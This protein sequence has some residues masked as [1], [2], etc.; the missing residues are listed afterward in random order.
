MYIWKRRLEC[1]INCNRPVVK[2]RSCL[3]KRATVT[4]LLQKVLFYVIK[5]SFFRILIVVAGFRVWL[6]EFV[7]SPNSSVELDLGDLAKFLNSLLRRGLLGSTFCK[8]SLF[9]GRHCSFRI[10]NR[11]CQS[12]LD[13]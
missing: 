2:I 8:L 6:L 3:R 7:L 4:F 11:N 5:F 9:C 10:I 13:E 12:D 1:V